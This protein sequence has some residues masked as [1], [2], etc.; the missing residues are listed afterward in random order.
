M[1]KYTLTKRPKWHYLAVVLALLICIELVNFFSGRW[2]NHFAIVP[3]H[4][5]TLVYIFTAP[6]LHGSLSHFFSNIVTLAVLSYLLMQFSVKRYFLVS[7][8]LIVMTGLLVWLFGREA[9]HLGASGV[10]YGYFA[11][12]LLA[13]FLSR[14]FFL[15]IISIAVLFFY[16]GM[17]WGVLPSQPFISW[18]SHLF[19]FISGL[20][21]AW[22]LRPT[23]H[24]R[25]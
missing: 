9:R 22:V 4:L 3:R 16:G 18:E 24:I 19:G 17:I 11:Y 14:R 13:G 7:I 1:T 5:D 10:I 21:L 25:K 2:L 6:W 8:L 15:A 12:L 23:A 20:V